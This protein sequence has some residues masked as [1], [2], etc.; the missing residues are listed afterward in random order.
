M[1]LSLKFRERCAAVGQFLVG[2]FD[3]L[4]SSIRTAWDVQH[5]DDGTHGAVTATSVTV[6]GTTTLT[7]LLTAIVATFSGVV[8]SLL[9]YRERGRTVPMGEWIPVAYVA[10]DYT[11]VGGGNWIT[12]AG[13]TLVYY[14][15]VGK[16]LT[17]YYE[18]TGTNVAGG[19]VTELNIKIPGGFVAARIFRNV[20]LSVD[21]AVAAVGFGMVSPAGTVVRLFSTVNS[22]G[23]VNQAVGAT[24]VYG[25]LI[26]EVQ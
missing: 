7:G 4:V 24:A 23:W 1:I 26:F 16:T 8:T 20:N 18:V 14:T 12:A 5:N 9:G 19:V 22:G 11:G 21:N 2:E 6:S 25:V 10:G 3:N 15:L 17:I 13:T